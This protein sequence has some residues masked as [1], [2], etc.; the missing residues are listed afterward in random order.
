[1][2]SRAARLGLLVGLAACHKAAAPAA[3]DAAPGPTLACRPLA[4]GS[5]VRV[6]AD[7][8]GVTRGGLYADGKLRGMSKFSMDQTVEFT[9][10]VEALSAGRPTRARLHFDTYVANDL[11]G[12]TL[13][14]VLEGK[15]YVLEPDRV[16]DEKG[17]PV[18]AAE[19]VIVQNDAKVIEERDIVRCGVPLRRDEKVDGPHGTAVLRAVVDGQLRF[20]IS[21]TLHRV[22]VLGPALIEMDQ[23]A[24][25]SFTVDSAGTYQSRVDGP[26]KVSG[27]FTEKGH[28]ITF[29]ATGPVER[30]LKITVDK[31]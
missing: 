18:S 7:T 10:E 5:V 2:C 21:G 9:F 24:D 16:T 3:P 11:T 28:A 8:S 6:H 22:G 4:V 1:M 13:H 30:K 12:A 19:T 15:T 17:K 31:L 26:A 23:H 14:M 29:S 27:S 20:D 25:G